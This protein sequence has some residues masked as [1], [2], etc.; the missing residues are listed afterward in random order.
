MV[1][2]FSLM[3]KCILIIPK[4]IKERK[5]NVCRII[6][7]KSLNTD[8]VDQLI[9][10]V[11]QCVPTDTITYKCIFF[12]ALGQNTSQET[13]RSLCLGVSVTLR[14]ELRWEVSNEVPVNACLFVW[15]VY[16]Y[17]TSI[18]HSKNESQFNLAAWPWSWWGFFVLIAL[19]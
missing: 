14:Q 10:C 7:S 2:P 4:S 11:L 18:D 16:D 8:L 3:T 17:R 5:R 1:L 9:N 15:W 19:T 13:E 12:L 6:S